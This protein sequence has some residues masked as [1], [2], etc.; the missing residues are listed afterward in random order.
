MEKKKNIAE[1]MWFE[2]NIFISKMLKLPAFHFLAHEYSQQRQQPRTDE[3]LMDEKLFLICHIP[4]LSLDIH[5]LSL[6][7]IKIDANDILRLSFLIY[8]GKQ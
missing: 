1:F 3:D 8:F 2:K 6:Y 4:F 7:C 5:V